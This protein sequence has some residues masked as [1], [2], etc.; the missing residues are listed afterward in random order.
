VAR[1]RKFTEQQWAEAL[2][3]YVTDGPTAAAARTGIDKGNLTRRAKALGLTTVVIASTHEATE[4]IALQRRLAFEEVTLGMIR[5]E[6]EMLALASSTHVI[7][8][9]QAGTSR[10]V[11]GLM[12]EEFRAVA[13]GF[14]ALDKTL[15]LRTGQATER[16]EAT[17]TKVPVVT[18]PDHEW[19]LLAEAIHRELADR[20]EAAAEAAAPQLLDGLS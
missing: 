20:A 10:E 8:V 5:I 6:Q 12:P 13:Q 2:S 4:T 15:M 17:V 19:D 18:L 16:S 9:G 3:L 7:F 1:P 14:A 11:K